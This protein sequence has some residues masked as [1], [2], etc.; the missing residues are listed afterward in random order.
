K[1]KIESGQ[2]HLVVLDEV[3]YPINWGWLDV[4]EVVSSIQNRPEKVNVILTGRDAPDRLIEIAD[5]V[6]EMTKIK[7]AFDRGVMARRGIDY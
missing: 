3:T 7:H 4:E 6:T 1:E 2:Y 5:T